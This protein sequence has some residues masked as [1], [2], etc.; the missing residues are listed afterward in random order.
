M[1]LYCAR[2]IGVA[3]W[4]VIVTLVT[5]AWFPFRFKDTNNNRLYCR[6]MTGPVLKILGIDL[7]MRHAERVH[8]VLPCIYIGNHQASLDIATHGSLFPR[9]T[10]IIAK[11]ALALIPGF[12]WVFYMAGNL[13]VQRQNRS[14]AMGIMRLAH[15]AVSERGVSIWI[16][17]EGTRSY[18]KGLGPFKK[19]AF[20]CAIDNQVPLVP[21]VV[22]TYKGNINFKRWRAGTV[23]VEVLEPVETRGLTVAEIDALITRA[24]ETCASA[25]A[26]LDAELA[27]V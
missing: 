25:I 3:A 13:L 4:F 9:R 1:L 18:G 21:I 26:R 27:R 22:S 17:P 15:E 5:M 24:H 23:I 16:Y 14:Q 11:K 19:G 20:H 2:L 8:A 10:V 7:R 6:L 12:G